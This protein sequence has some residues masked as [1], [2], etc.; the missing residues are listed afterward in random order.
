MTVLSKIFMLV[1]LIS[2][3]F[4]F[5]QDLA[6]TNGQSMDVL[7]N[8]VLFVNG[9]EFNSSMDFQI[10]APNSIIRSSTPLN[11]QSIERVINFDTALNN[12]QGSLTLHYEDSE[13]NGLDENNLV[14]NLEDAS[15]IITNYVGALDTTLN[16][17]QY[18]FLLPISFI[19]VTATESS[20]LSLTDLGEHSISVFPNPTKNRVNIAIPFD[21]ETIVYDIN[22]RKIMQTEEK[23][24]DL[25]HL[26][27]GLYLFEIRNLSDGN[28]N[29]FKVLKH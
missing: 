7:S 18:D 2:N 1:F 12:Y 4:S 10:T 9:L 19:S 26:H 6:F 23:L 5:G 27:S 25:S 15:T 14:L 24:I 16:T 3:N 13:L 17:L 22:G 28:L 8:T 21:V 29:V 20:T 11:A